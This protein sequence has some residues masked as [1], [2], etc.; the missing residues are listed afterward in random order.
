[1]IC[2]SEA[3]HPCQMMFTVTVNVKGV[4]KQKRN[5]EV[6]SS[7]SATFSQSMLVCCQ[8]AHWMPE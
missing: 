4:P 2:D 5:G 1:M 7:E 3:P 6:G 8:Q